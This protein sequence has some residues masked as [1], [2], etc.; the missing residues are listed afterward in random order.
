MTRP[1]THIDPNQK[2]CMRVMAQA[3]N[4]PNHEADLEMGEEDMALP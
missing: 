1:Y 4:D 2:S 3:R